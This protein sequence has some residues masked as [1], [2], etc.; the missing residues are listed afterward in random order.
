MGCG[1]SHQSSKSPY[2]MMNDD[3]VPL[4]MKFK[5][6]NHTKGNV[7]FFFISFANEVFDEE[8]KGLSLKRLRFESLRFFKRKS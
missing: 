4:L 7:L 5:S 8:N 2:F 6:G 1:L 3:I